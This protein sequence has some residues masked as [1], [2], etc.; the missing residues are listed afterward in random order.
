MSQVTADLNNRSSVQQK[1]AIE[2]LHLRYGRPDLFLRSQFVETLPRLHRR[3][4]DSAPLQRIDFRQVMVDVLH[5]A[6]RS[7]DLAGVERSLRR[8]LRQGEISLSSLR[9]PY[10]LRPPRGLTGVPQLAN[11]E[12]TLSSDDE[13]QGGASQLASSGTRQGCGGC[14]MRPSY[15]SP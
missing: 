11:P 6:V 5:V 3:A 15:R 7:G 14:Y 1:L 9:D 13:L 12:H 4:G 8:Q 2:R 10:G